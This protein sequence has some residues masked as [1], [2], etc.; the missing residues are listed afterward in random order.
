MRLLTLV[1]F[2]ASLLVGTAAPSIAAPDP[3]LSPVKDLP[4]GFD[5]TKMLNA[6]AGV[7]VNDG[8]RREISVDGT[9]VGV[10]SP[11]ATVALIFYLKYPPALP[12]EVRIELAKKGFVLPWCNALAPITL[13][14]RVSRAVVN[15]DGVG[16]GDVSVYNVATYGVPGCAGNNEFLQEVK[17][18]GEDFNRAR[19]NYTGVYLFGFNSIGEVKWDS[20]SPAQIASDAQRAEAERQARK[21]EEER[22]A[23]EVY[24]K[25]QEER[26]RDAAERAPLPSEQ[27]ASLHSDLQ[28]LLKKKDFSAAEKRYDEACTEKKSGNAQ[29]QF[30]LGLMLVEKARTARNSKELLAEARYRLEKAFNQYESSYPEAVYTGEDLDIKTRA[31]AALL[32]LLNLKG[33]DAQWEKEI[34]EYLASSEFSSAAQKRL[35]AKRLAEIETEEARQRKA[36]EAK[37]E[38]ERIAEQGRAKQKERDDQALFAKE[39]RRRIEEAKKADASIA[40]ENARALAEERRRPRTAE[41]KLVV[42]AREDPKVMELLNRMGKAPSA[43]PVP[44]PTPQPQ[45]RP[46]GDGSADDTQCQGFGWD[47]GTQGYAGCRQQ[48][49]QLRADQERHRQALVAYQEQVQ[50]YEREAE[51]QRGERMFIQGMR[52]LGGGR[53]A[54]SGSSLGPAPVA[55]ISPPTNYYIRDRYGNSVNCS[56]QTFG[57]TTNVNCR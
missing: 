49:N 5:I 32:P 18:G 17:R 51:R 23:Q 9:V 36:E 1:A 4:P 29:C 38:R 14:E 26:Q 12:T 45:A 25:M 27:F 24:S 40:R 53:G 31:A 39:E 19:L 46:S 10:I 41:E 43:A 30:L 6:G 21:R 52:I 44:A 11:G 22:K 57:S 35:A 37:A 55:P 2:A 16:F 15:S 8:E 54:S 20:R 3:M 34:V 56:A 48:L 7:I 47:V 28:V 13:Y 33:E 42:L 50:A